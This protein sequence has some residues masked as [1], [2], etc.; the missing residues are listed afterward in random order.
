MIPQQNVMNEVF[1]K[2]VTFYNLSFIECALDKLS[3]RIHKP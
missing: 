1:N 2:F 3:K